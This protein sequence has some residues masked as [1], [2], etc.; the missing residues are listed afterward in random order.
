MLGQLEERPREPMSWPTRACRRSRRG[1]VM[2]VGV[3]VAR[4]PTP[5]ESNIYSSQAVRLFLENS[6]I[7]GGAHS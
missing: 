1:Q 5:A 3:P 7:L 6:A 4:D 2:E